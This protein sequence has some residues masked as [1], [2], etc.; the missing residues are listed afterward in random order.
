M[1]TFY[2]DQTGAC[3]GS[4]DGPPGE[5]PWSGGAITTPPE[6]A[7]LQR[8]DG[9][10]WVW[11][12]EALREKLLAT[13]SEQYL[14]A[15]QRGLPYGGKV[16]QIR[17]QDQPNLTT[18][19]SEARWAKAVNAAW[20]SDFAWRMADNSF[21]ILPNVDAMIA[22]ADAAKAEVYRLQRVKWAHVDAVRA[23]V[24]SSDIA[25]YNFAAGW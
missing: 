17:E 22:L 2:V 8:W 1:Q 15:L 7:T 6:D 20:A 4:F 3:L 10:T 14:L 11:P 9:L 19:G 25:A 13:I 5:S 18:M 23:L 12:T 16:L 21:L 24:Q